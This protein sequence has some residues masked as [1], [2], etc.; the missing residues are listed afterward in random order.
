MSDNQRRGYWGVIPGEIKHDPKLTIAARYLYIILSSM[1]YE[2]G[3]CW[4]SNEFLAGEMGLSKRRVV[5]LLGLLRD[6]G[7][8]KIIMKSCEDT[9][10]G[11][12]RYIYCGMFPERVE[13]HEEGCEI[14]HGEDAEDCTEG[15]EKPHGGDAKIR[16]PIVVEKQKQKRNITL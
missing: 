11:E 15:G 16:L 6:C 14:S 9:P 13:M 7:Y 4:P 3:Y 5:E 10:N 1:A 2:D 8:I 12:R